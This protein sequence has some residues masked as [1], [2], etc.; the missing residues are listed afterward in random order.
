M[1]LGVAGMII[2]SENLNHSQKFP[3]LSTSKSWFI[4]QFHP[5]KRRTNAGRRPPHEGV[6]VR[7]SPGHEFC[8]ELLR[9]WGNPQVEHMDFP[10]FNILGTKKI[11]GFPTKWLIEL[12]GIKNWFIWDN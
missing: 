2:T 11:W 7:P 4:P 5:K 10:F 12:I 1:G 6:A 9:K 3:T 8:R